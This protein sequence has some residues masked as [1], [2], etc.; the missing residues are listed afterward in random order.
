MKKL[1][2]LLIIPTI[3]YSQITYSDIL[4]INSFKTYK[5]VMIENGFEF[6]SVDS[7]TVYENYVYEDYIYGLNI[8]R[9][10]DGNRSSLWT[11]YSKHN[12]EFVFKFVREGTNKYGN[13]IIMETP[14]DEIIRKIKNRC[15]YVDILNRYDLDYVCYQCP[16]STFKGYIGFTVSEGVGYVRHIVYNDYTDSDETEKEE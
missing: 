13:D 7:F 5:R 11:I 15:K 16:Q 6:S 9:S 3:S 1:L 4:N 8:K 14:Y 12:D 10:D 2:L